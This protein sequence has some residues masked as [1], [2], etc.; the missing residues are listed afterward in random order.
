MLK[1]INKLIIPQPSIH[2]KNIHSGEVFS[3]LCKQLEQGLWRDII[4]ENY[5][6]N[7]MQGL[8]KRPT[9]KPELKDVLPI[10]PRMKWCKEKKQLQDPYFIPVKQETSLKD[11]L[12]AAESFFA[13]Y[14]DKKI[15]VQLS[16]GLDSSIIIGLLK[17]FD[18]PFSL[19]GMYSNRYEFRTER[20]VQHILAEWG[21]PTSLIKYENHLPFFDLE[22]IPP[23]QHPDHLSLNYSANNVMAVEC[24]KLGIDILLTGNGG[25]NVFSDEVPEN[26]EYCR[27]KP[28]VFI[29]TWLNDIVYAPQGVK[30]IPFYGDSQI[31]GAIYNL[32]IGQKE[33]N[34]KIWARNFF[35]DFLPVELVNYTYCA[36]FWGLYISGLQNSLFIVRK[37][38]TRAY[39]FT[40]H[41]YFSD[42]AISEM[43]N[44][45]LLNAEKTMYQKIE[46]RISLATWIN[47][48]INIEN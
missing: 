46:S 24:E 15:G 2:F 39:E 19:V 9:W 14:S 7:T 25:D 32:R 37:L 36:D 45:D 47:A 3:D 16:G 35:K 20:R 44:Q 40:E 5:E 34:T 31:M 27:W 42:I 13:K 11:F 41:P 26:P 29:D 12:M 8:L 18:I 10:Y 38:C 30:L 33:D 22:K 23:F 17:Y 48:L 6:Y 4:P 21:Y 43:F 1:P 28:Q